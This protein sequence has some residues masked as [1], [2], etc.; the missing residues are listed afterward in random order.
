MNLKRLSGLTLGTAAS[1]LAL[2]VQPSCSVV[3]NDFNQQ[4][5]TTQDCV[6]LAARQPLGIDGKPISGLVCS[7]QHVCVP[8]GGCHSNVECQDAHNGEPYLC[9]SSDRTCQSLILP[10][11]TAGDPNVCEILAD[12]DDIK[13]ENTIWLGASVIFAPGSYQG[14]EMVRQDFN[15]LAQGLPPA[16]ATG[17]NRRKLAF[18]YCEA[19]DTLDDGAAHL[20]NDLEL[21]AIITSL[22]TSSEIEVLTKY[23]LAANKKVFQL[24]TS[25]GGPLLK[26]IDNQGM[27]IDLVLINENYDKETSEVVTQHYVPLLR[28]SGGPLTATQLPRVAVIHSA[29][30]TYSHSSSGIVSHLQATF[31][32]GHQAN[33]KEFP[34]GDANEPSGNPGAYAGVVADVLDFKPHIIIVLGDDEIGPAVDPMTQMV[35]S[36][37][38]DVPIETKWATAVPGQPP[39]LWLGILGAVG[40]L[41]K[42][43]RTLKDPAAQ[44]DWGSRSLFIQ[45]HYDFN[46]KQF[47]NYINQ[48]KQIVGSDDPNDIIATE[49]T[50]PYNEFLREGAYLTAYSVALLAAQ[51]KEVSGE[52]LAAAARSFG[53]Q[54]MPRNFTVGPEDLF[55]SLQSI[56]SSKLPFDLQN[57]QGWIGFDENGFAKY[58]TTDDVACVTPAVDPDLG[59]ATVGSLQPTGGIFDGEGALS[60][61]D[62]GWMTGDDPVSLTGCAGN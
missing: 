37:G 11:A 34:Y 17:K 36:D 7:D 4:C 31:G 1:C 30:Y 32:P 28:K 23:S 57:F 39:P 2:M 44:V 43:I 29:T 54:N 47:T 60:S 42:D 13:D 3:V 9:R 16:T 50:S 45:Q 24:S 58:P 51:G 18:V 56:Q 33:V 59:T 10:A 5:T 19:I 52:N 22:D 49:G 12:P 14:L 55:P 15:R 62:T 48:L 40:Q 35:T 53:S 46:G 61:S 41:P 25:A 20:I 21:P 38:I 8:E 26:T 27:L 6:D